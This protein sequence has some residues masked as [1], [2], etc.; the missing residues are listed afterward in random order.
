VK[1]LVNLPLWAFHGADDPTVPVS[2]TREIIAA[3][4]ALGGHPRYT[5]YPA[6]AGYGHFSWNPAYADP[7]LLP[8][9]FGPPAAKR[10]P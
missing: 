1:S 6:S 3:L 4:R 10:K 9:M 2:R 7:D 8:W 5:E